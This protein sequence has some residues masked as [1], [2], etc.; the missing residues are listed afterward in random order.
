MN[1]SQGNNDASVRI[2]PA[3]EADF[4]AIVKFADQNIGVDYFSVEKVKSI[5]KASTQ[6]EVMCSFVLENLE[7]HCL[8]GIRLTYAP[9]VWPARHP[10]QSIHAHLWQVPVE[11]T[12]YFQSLFVSQRFQNQGWGQ[13]LSM[14]SVENLK[15]LGAKAVVCH[16]W[17]ESPGNSSRKYLNSLGFEPVISIPNFWHEID[18][19]C[20]RCGRGCKCTATE[21]ILYL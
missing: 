14:A 4:A 5:L 9:G 6:N 12:A 17:D 13:R 11:Q 19:E 2:R 16:S 10:S 8:E 15:L 18:Y 20:T 21:M 1:S 3:R 7:S